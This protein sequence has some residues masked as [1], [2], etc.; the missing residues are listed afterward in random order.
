M[1]YIKPKAEPWAKMTRLI[2]GYGI[3]TTALANIL[4]VS[5]PTASRRINNPGT[6]T[7]EELYAINTKG[8]IPLEEIKEAISR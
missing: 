5:Q 2:R 7:L 8:H 1:P 3:T 6:L 4:N